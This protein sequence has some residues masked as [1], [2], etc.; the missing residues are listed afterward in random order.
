[1]VALAANEKCIATQWV[2]ALHLNSGHKGQPIPDGYRIL[3]TRF[4]LQI[5]DALAGCFSHSAKNYPDIEAFSELRMP[6][7]PTAPPL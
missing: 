6:R 1:M 5:A 3:K 2:I 7:R 4:V